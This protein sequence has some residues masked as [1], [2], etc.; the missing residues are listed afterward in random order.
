MNAPLE[1]QTSRIVLRPIRIED[2]QLILDLVNSAEWIRHISNLGIH[3]QKQT[4]EYIKKRMLP[5]YERLGFG[6]FCI[7]RLSD[8]KKIGTCSMYDR[9]GHEGFDLGFALLPEFQGKGY[10]FEAS[11]TLMDWMYKRGE[12]KLSAYTLEDNLS[13]RKLLERLGF[14]HI[15]DVQ[16][17]ND[18]RSWMHYIHSI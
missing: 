1:I 12:T 9:P 14:R 3:T 10:A 6:N 4:E 15:G 18:H 16:L 5:Q 11:E 17:E 2:A 7:E 13:S 8:H